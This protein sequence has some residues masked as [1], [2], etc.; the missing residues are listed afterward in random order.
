MKECKCMEQMRQKVEELT[1]MMR[2]NDLDMRVGEGEYEDSATA[3][4]M[5]EVIHLHQE[6]NGVKGV[7]YRNFAIKKSSV[8]W[9]VAKEG[10]QEFHAKGEEVKGLKKQIGTPWGWAGGRMLMKAATDEALTKEEK[11]EIEKKLFEYMG[12][13]KYGEEGC[14][15]DYGK[16][17]ELHRVI[18]FV[19][20]TE[21]KDE[22]YLTYGC[23]KGAERMEELMAKVL[24]A[25]GATKKDDR[26]PKATV[27]DM[28]AALVKRNKW[29][30]GKGKGKK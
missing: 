4:M 11:E 23:K 15:V 30:K 2:K 13:G 27:K 1:M 12:K 3:M 6:M 22:N 19:E 29:G 26:P 14:T 18:A 28:K 8:Y 9:A 25:E 20:M 17:T 21:G 5:R 16:V 7:V 10:R 24:V